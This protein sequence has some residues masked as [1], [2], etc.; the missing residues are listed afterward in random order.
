M[1][2]AAIGEK[3]GVSLCVR[4][5]QRFQAQHGIYLPRS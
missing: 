2:E 3:V 5:K 1:E 4:V